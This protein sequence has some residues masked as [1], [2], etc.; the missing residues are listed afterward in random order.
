MLS[1]AR[2]SQAFGA[3]RANR[4]FEI[5]RGDDSAARVRVLDEYVTVAR[6]RAKRSSRM[7]RE[8]RAIRYFFKRL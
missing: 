2:L 8:G 6:K 4:R 1:P 7:A 5:E 3:Y